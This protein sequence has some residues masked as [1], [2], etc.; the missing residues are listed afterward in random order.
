[1]EITLVAPSKLKIFN[2][3]KFG[4]SFCC[5]MQNNKDRKDYNNDKD[6]NSINLKKMIRQCDECRRSYFG[7]L[8]CSPHLLPCGHSICEI[9]V[10]TKKGNKSYCVRCLKDITENY[11]YP[12]HIK[13]IEVLKD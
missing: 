4:N 1:M 10:Y 7:K 9:C 3:L 13:M 8:F 6:K 2:L 12:L 5:E 11:N